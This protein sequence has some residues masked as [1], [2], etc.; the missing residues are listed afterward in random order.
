MKGSILRIGL[1]AVVGLIGCN[2]SK[3]VGNH[4]RVGASG[5]ELTIKAPDTLYANFQPGTGSGPDRETFEVALTVKNPT[6]KVFEGKA[7]S[8]NIAVVVVKDEGT[9]KEIFKS[10]GGTMMTDVRIEKGASETYKQTVEIADI[11]PYAPGS[12][13]VTATFAPTGESVSKSI[14][15]KPVR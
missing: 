8:T 4:E 7:P 9:G 13:L 15:V 6:A 3:D 10:V 2:S 14:T 1:L 11:K 5:L 12:L